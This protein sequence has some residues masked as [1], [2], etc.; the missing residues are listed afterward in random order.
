MRKSDLDKSSPQY[1]EGT[2][3]I[4]VLCFIGFLFLMLIAHLT[5]LELWGKQ[6]F[7]DNTFNQR[8]W[9]QEK[10][11]LRGE[12][13]DRNGEILA[14]SKF[15]EEGDNQVRI[16]PYDNLYSHVIG[17]SSR[18]YGKS[19]LELNFNKNLAG[20]SEISGFTLDEEKKGETLNLTISHALQKR[21][22]DL[23]G[24]NIGA[25][26]ALEPNT[27]EVL[28]MYSYPNFNPSDE[29]LSEQWESLTANKDAPFLQRATS[30]LYTPGSVMKTIWTSAAI[31]NNID[32]GV[33]DDEGEIEI[34]GK[35]F[36][37]AKGKSYGEIDLKKGFAVSSNVA[38][39]RLSD[40]LGTKL[41]TDYAEKFMFDAKIPFELST[42]TPKFGHDEKMSRTERASVSIGQGKILT[43]P[44]HM[45][46]ICGAIAND[47]VMMQP[48]LVEKSVGSNGLITYSGKSTILKRTIKTSVASELKDY[49]IEVVKSG[50]GTNA[51]I[52]GVTVAGKSGTAETGENTK[53][54]SWF[55]AFAPAENPT[56]AVAVVLEHGGSGGGSA[57][58]P[59]AREIINTWL[60]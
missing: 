31:E 53:D 40:M 57:A 7:M 41:M 16:Y 44:L 25:V 37:N 8:Q 14:Y 47:G 34:D 19:Q 28:C 22:K 29:I 4:I 49:M 23:L 21:A 46:M 35:T 3:F 32:F 5:V 42:E 51:K 39:I 15:T 27:G 38:F 12:I 20:V 26:V 54:H 45:A 18:V 24:K 17:Y 52:K 50:T 2:R 1:K 9:E 10:R 43:T 55:I 13:T 30:G 58:A 33:F 11:I 56:I 60:D 59:I 36:K 6:K 48:Y